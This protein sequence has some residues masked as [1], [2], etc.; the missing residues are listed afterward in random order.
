MSYFDKTTGEEFICQVFIASLGYSQKTYI[1]AY[2][3]QKVLDFIDALNKCV[4]YFGGVP[5]AIVPD[6]LKSTVI[7]SDRYEPT[8]NRVLEDWA[9]H[10]DTTIL[11][12]RA[13][14]PKDK[15][16]V[17]GAVKTAY[18]RVYA[19]LRDKIFTSI[20]D[21]NQAIDAENI[22][23]NN[24]KFQKKT[25]QDKNCLILKKSRFYKLCH[26]QHL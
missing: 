17:E 5:K 18:S 4:V 21:L 25:S 15:S 6:N 19:P 1:Q 8:L 3:S 12:A 16:L 9:N 14:K 22:R 7:K 20:Y 26:L 13:A 11:P 10:N 2:A 23:H 24:T